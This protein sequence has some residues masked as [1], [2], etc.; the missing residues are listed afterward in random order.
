MAD[1]IIVNE[2]RGSL[3]ADVFSDGGGHFHPSMSWRSVVAGLVIA[4]FSYVL[5]MSLGVAIGSVSLIDGLQTDAGNAGI[6][7]GLWMI[8]A[9]ALSLFVG[10]YLASRVSKYVAP[11]VGSAQSAVIT[12]L[13]FGVL[14]FQMA[15]TLGAAS[16]TVGS[17]MGGAAQGAMNL[18]SY[19]AV[20]GVVG[21]ALGGLN[22]NSSPEVVAQ[23]VAT[24]LLRGD[25]ESA[26]DF[27]AAQAGMT[28]TEAQARIDQAQTDVRAALAQAGS[29]AARAMSTAAWSLFAMMVVGLLAAVGG[30]VF[31]SRT[32]VRKPLSRSEVSMRGYRTSPA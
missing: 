10:S 3:E 25:A 12:A 2:G 27:L 6:M 13:F 11:M 14:L 22:L 1:R 4:L 21:E 20:Q 15:A 19:P 26:R 5:L 29:E 28:P 7:A 16:R 32:N 8:V 18:S 17:M 30:G 31:G 24:R 9:A 23:G